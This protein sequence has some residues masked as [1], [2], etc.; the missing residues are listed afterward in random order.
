MIDQGDLAVAI[1]ADSD[2]DDDA[3]DDEVRNTDSLFVVAQTDDDDSHLEVQLY[4]EDGTLYVHHDIYLPE[5]PICLAWLDCPPYL[6]DGTQ[7]NVGNYV[8]VGTFS[9]GIEIWNL[10]VLDPLEPSATLGGISANQSKKG[11]KNKPKLVDGSHTEAVMALSWNK[12]FRQAIASGSAD[13]TIKI[14]DVTTQKCSHTFKHHNDKVCRTFYS[15]FIFIL[16]RCKVFYGIL[17]K[18]GYYHLPLLTRQ[19]HFLIAGLV[20]MDYLFLL[21][22]I[23]NH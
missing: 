1:G 15:Y 6:D 13:T 7:V 14:W 4:S 18:V 19:W 8:A 22:V 20:P 11:K 5:F 17:L 12:S 9:P 21:Q 2:E 16:F 3:S 10:D 23:L